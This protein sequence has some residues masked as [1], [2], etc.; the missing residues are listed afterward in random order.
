VTPLDASNVRRGF[1]ALDMK[2]GIEGAWTPRLRAIG[3]G[4]E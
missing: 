2:T 3:I 1:Q 4:M